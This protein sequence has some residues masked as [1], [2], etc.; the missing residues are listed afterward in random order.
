ML[1][2][3]GTA[4]VDD[5][6]DRRMPTRNA[7]RG[8]MPLDDENGGD[9]DDDFGPGGF[10]GNRSMGGIGIGPMEG[11]MERMGGGIG[12]GRNMRNM[13][14]IRGAV[15]PV[16]GNMERMAGGSGF[17]GNM[18]SMGGIGGGVG[19]MGGNMEMVGEGNIMGSMMM[20]RMGGIMGAGLMAGVGGGPMGLMGTNLDGLSRLASEMEQMNTMQGNLR[21]MAGA[22]GNMRRPVDVMERGRE[23]DD[24]MERGGRPRS[25]HD[26]SEGQ[27]QEAE[28][29]GTIVLVSNMNHEVLNTHTLFVLLLQFCPSVTCHCQLYS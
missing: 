15:G 22:S 8:R 11:N 7:P 28:S 12:F 2:L 23:R 6:H 16:G 24:R 21:G 13:S 27:Q 17:G 29:I 18:R 10:G 1:V 19:P 14:G 3:A 20:N 25:R 9:I 4:A 5:M 26:T